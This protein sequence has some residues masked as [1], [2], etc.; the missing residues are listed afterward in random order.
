[1]ESTLGGKFWGSE[2]KCGS[3]MHTGGE[4]LRLCWN[5]SYV[6]WMEVGLEEAGQEPC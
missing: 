5:H 6:L 4:G 1:M 3:C 2:R